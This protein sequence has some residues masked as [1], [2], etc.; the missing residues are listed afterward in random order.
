MTSSLLENSWTEGNLKD[1]LKK[2]W[3]EYINGGWIKHSVAGVGQS[4]M[5]TYD[6]LTISRNENLE[7]MKEYHRSN[8]SLK[9]FEYPLQPSTWMEGL[10][11]NQMKWNSSVEMYLNNTL[12]KWYYPHSSPTKNK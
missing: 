7:T 10:Y 12:T 4:A 3:G 1:G 2:G 6:P 9:R 8:K 5:D 11:H